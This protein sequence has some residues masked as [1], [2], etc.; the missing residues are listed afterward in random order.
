ML[1]AGPGWN[2]QTLTQFYPDVDT[3]TRQLRA[4][5][6]AAKD[7]PSSADDR[8][9]LAYHYLVMGYNE[10][11][12]KR[13]EQ[14]HALVPDDQLTTQLLAALKPQSPDKS[15]MPQPGTG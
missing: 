12:A 2:W 5:E 9:V 10:D 1:S 3:Y 8:F 7:N 11:A 13:F 14:V 4:L 6:V 15:D